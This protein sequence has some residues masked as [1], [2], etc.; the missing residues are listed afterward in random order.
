MDK[1]SLIWPAQ[2][3]II[4]TKVIL[5]LKRINS[6]SKKTPS[7]Q[8]ASPYIGT[9]GGQLSHVMQNMHIWIIIQD[10]VG[11]IS[12]FCPNVY[13][14]PKMWPRP[15]EAPMHGPPPPEWWHIFEEPPE[16]FNFNM[17]PITTSQD[18]GGQISMFL[19]KQNWL[20]VRHWVYD[21][22]SERG[23]AYFLLHSVLQTTVMTAARS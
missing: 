3:W 1:K 15:P 23:G 17:T 7:L 16:C 20:C 6:S 2:S 4:T 10:C 11:Q 18:C 22:F 19:S 13:I 5:K 8:G 9:P 14:L 21:Y 12:D